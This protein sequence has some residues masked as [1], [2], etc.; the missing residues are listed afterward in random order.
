[1]ARVSPTCL[2]VKQ[3]VGGIVG[4]GFLK[5]GQVRGGFAV[6]LAVAVRKK[7][8][9]SELP[10]LPVEGAAAFPA[11]LGA[12]GVLRGAWRGV[13]GP[14]RGGPGSPFRAWRRRAGPGSAGTRFVSSVLVRAIVRGWCE[15]QEHE[16][17]GGGDG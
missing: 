16:M 13:A 9:R 11:L 14:A 6:E 17:G 5:G 2:P 7:R 15:T 4:D 1:V 12:S 8:P 3:I 10:F